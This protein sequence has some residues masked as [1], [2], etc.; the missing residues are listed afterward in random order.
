MSGHNYSYFCGCA[1]CC[2]QEA[3]DERNEAYMD[4][5]V[6][7]LCLLPALI[8]EVA[9]E[10]DEAA[11]AANALRTNDVAGFA[12]VWTD[13]IERYARER[14]AAQAKAFR[15]SDTDAAERL[16]RVYATRGAA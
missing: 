6:R 2:E 12:E 1:Q 10:D 8:A 5:L 3:A 4:T 11:L 16:C 13:A 15:E 9:L 7:D 14:I